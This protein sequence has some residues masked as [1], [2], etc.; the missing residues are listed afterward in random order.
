MIPLRPAG[1]K[2]QPANINAGLA[3]KSD[4]QLWWVHSGKTGAIASE[5]ASSNAHQGKSK[6]YR[7]C[8][9]ISFIPQGAPTGSAG[10]RT[11]RTT[12]ALAAAISITTAINRCESREPGKVRTVLPEICVLEVGVI[13]AE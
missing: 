5:H 9:V 12:A 7:H 3:A 2:P 11:D 13:D 6:G 1:K 10:V 4:K 8:P